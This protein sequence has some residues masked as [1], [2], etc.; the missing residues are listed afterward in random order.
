[1]ILN[2][3]FVRTRRQDLSLSQ[4]QLAEAVGVSTTVIASLEAGTNHESLSVGLVAKL[5]KALAVEVHDLFARAVPRKTMDTHP[6][7]PSVGALLAETPSLIAV[8]A[9]A[10]ALGITLPE[11]NGALAD[12]ERRLPAVGMMLHR[13]NGDVA[14]RPQAT[15]D[16]DVR[17][18]LIRK[19]HARRGLTLTEARVLYRV[20]QGG[21][22]EG[23]LSNPDGVALNRLR[24]AGLVTDDVRPELSE[25]VAAGLSASLANRVEG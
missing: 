18:H 13:L 3:P 12:L 22:D 10:E 4:R 20:A 17:K 6:H 16:P 1:M 19:H 8:D 11:T 23:K 5:A 14:I 21:V 9:I 15:I 25:D 7:T 24:R 2:G